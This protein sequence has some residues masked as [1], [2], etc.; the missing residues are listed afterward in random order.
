L[1]IAENAVAAGAKKVDIRVSEDEANDLLRIEIAD[2]GKGM[3]P[4]ALK[5]A[6]DP[7]FTTTEGKKV[8]LG[9]SLLAQ[10][11]R[12]CDGQ[13]EI[14]SKPRGTR[15]T[16]VKATFRRSHIDRKPVGD[17]AQTLATLVAGHPDVRFT[18][19]HRKG[20][21]EY[22]LDTDD[23]PASELRRAGTEDNGFSQAHR[24]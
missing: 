7:F 6:T 10:A 16:V 2:D 23:P 14:E 5:K 4:E 11:T 24:T 12:E 1:D 17:M 20:E 9:L 19:V 15:G 21:M 18:Y 22:S 3:N 8:G 13:L